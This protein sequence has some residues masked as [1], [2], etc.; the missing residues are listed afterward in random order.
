MMHPFISDEVS[1]QGQIVPKF[2]FGFPGAFRRT[3]LLYYGRQVREACHFTTTCGVEDS[4]VRAIIAKDWDCVF[5][6][7]V[8]YPIHNQEEPCPVM[9]YCFFGLLPDLG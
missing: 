3:V 6:V 2:S 9:M 1:I 7:A 5:L 4:L 8:L